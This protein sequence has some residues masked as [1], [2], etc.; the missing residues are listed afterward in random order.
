L[1]FRMSSTEKPLNALLSANMAL[2]LGLTT[3]S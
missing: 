1:A 3:C 2:L